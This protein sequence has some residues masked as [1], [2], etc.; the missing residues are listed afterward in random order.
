MNNCVHI[1]QEQDGSLVA[2][3]DDLIAPG[4][5][6]HANGLKPPAETLESY[7]SIVQANAQD[8]ESIRLEMKALNPICCSIPMGGILSHDHRFIRSADNRADRAW[9]KVAGNSCR[10]E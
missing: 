8:A 9:R 3:S 5:L 2:W 1:T 10:P 7:G 4:A 6:R